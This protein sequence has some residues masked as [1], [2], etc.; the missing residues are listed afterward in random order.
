[1]L[2][3]EFVVGDASVAE[4]NFGLV[5]ALLQGYVARVTERPAFARALARESA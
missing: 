4:G 3:A 5:S 2:A 1:M